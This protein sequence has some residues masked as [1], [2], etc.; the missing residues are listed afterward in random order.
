MQKITL[1]LALISSAISA[2]A[3]CTYKQAQ[4][5]MMQVNNMLQVYSREIIKHRQNGQSVPA[6]LD[7]KQLAITEKS[8]AIGILMSEAFDKNPQIQF[9][10]AVNEEICNG[11][12]A[13]LKEYAPE[14]YQAK[15]IVREQQSQTSDCSTNKLWEDYG[16]AIQKQQQ[17]IES[18]KITKQE[19]DA[20]MLLATKIGEFATTDLPKA[21]QALKQFKQKLAAE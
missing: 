15:P 16:Q 18:G 19:V 13:L 2:N 7:T 9:S 4:D 10:D 1:T 20:Y 21:C 8:A 3:T 17:L 6:E 12:E 5:K 14:N 11:Y